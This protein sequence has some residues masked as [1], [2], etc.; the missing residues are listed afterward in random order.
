MSN[1]TIQHLE[2]L[3]QTATLWPPC[4]NQVE[5]HPYYQQK[6]LLEYCRKENIIVQSY[7]SLGGQDGT[8]AKWKSLGGKL[9]EAAPIVGIA[10]RLSKGK[11]RR[12]TPA[13]VLLRWSLQRNCAQVP[14][15]C[16][17]DR[18]LENA[19]IFD[20]ALTGEDMGVISGMAPGVEGDGRLCWRTEPLRM[21]DF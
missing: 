21:L 5:C 20:F 12:I 13:Q 11:N 7:S 8:K 15:S 9:L 10:E 16:K 6:D 17:P 2:T 3:K 1:F 14:K 18:Q 19:N 4:T